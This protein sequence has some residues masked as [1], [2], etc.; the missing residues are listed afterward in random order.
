MSGTAKPW[1]LFLTMFKI[2]AF[3]F[4]GGY[5]MVPLIQDEFVKKNKYLEQQ[6]MADILALS[7]SLPGAIAINA[8]VICGYKVA[9]IPGSIL[10][11][12]GMA[13]PSIISLTLVTFLYEWFK[14]N[15][16]VAGALKGIRASVVALLISAFLTLSKPFRKDVL[17]IAVFCAAF[18]VSFIFDVNSI[19]IIL[20]AIVFGI[21]VSIWRKRKHG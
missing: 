15:P 12:L 5:A 11:V 13:L 6:Q 21:A 14:T 4:G 8:S 1:K 2:G 20:A 3:T 18:L 16:Y 19:Y 17:G 7:Q 10:A 9:G